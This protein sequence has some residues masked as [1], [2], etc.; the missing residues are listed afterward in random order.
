L[1]EPGPATKSGEE[2]IGVALSK[3]L[4]IAE[5]K[6]RFQ[7][8][9]IDPVLKKYLQF[10]INRIEEEKIP[11]IIWHPLVQEYALDSSYLL[12][13]SDWNS[14]IDTDLKKYNYIDLNTLEGRKCDYFIDPIHA[15]VQC[16]GEFL[17][18]ILKNKSHQK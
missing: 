1:I 12:I 8:Y 16:Y 11:F 3:G 4:V 15:G 18:I 13:G 14:Y 5:L 9:N 10:T 2:N 7:S 17:E 6:K